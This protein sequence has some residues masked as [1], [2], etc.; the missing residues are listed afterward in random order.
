MLKAWQENEERA[1]A[2]AQVK[3]IYTVKRAGPP[4]LLRFQQLPGTSGKLFHIFQ[5]EKTQNIGDKQNK[6]W[7]PLIF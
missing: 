1:A 7:K 3:W 4:V 5:T 2:F 6:S